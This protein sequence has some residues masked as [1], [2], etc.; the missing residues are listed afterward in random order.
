MESLFRVVERSLSDP[1]VEDSADLG[2]ACRQGGT[3]PENCGRAPN[4][5]KISSWLNTPGDKPLT[6]KSLRGNVVLIDFWT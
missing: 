6:L 5:T 1:L 2:G 4:F 3:E